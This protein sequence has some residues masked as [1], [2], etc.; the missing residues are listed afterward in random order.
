LEKH[1]ASTFH[2]TLKMEATG[3]SIPFVHKY[4]STTQHS[5]TFNFTGHKNCYGEGRF[6]PCDA[7]LVWKAAITVKCTSTFQKHFKVTQPTEALD[8]LSLLK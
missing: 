4:L 6:A 3:S 5:I 2:S 8:I 1:D 7:A